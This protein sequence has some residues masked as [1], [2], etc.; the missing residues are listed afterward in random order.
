MN[1]VKHVLSSLLLWRLW[2]SIASAAPDSET[3]TSCAVAVVGGGWAGIY[4]AWRLVVDEKRFNGSEVCMFEAS[5]RIGGR[6]YTL[7]AHEA[8]QLEGL[9]IDIGAYRF[10]FEQHLPADL[11]RGPL[12]MSTGCYIPSCK[13]EPLDDDLVLHRLVDS[14]SGVSIGYGSALVL[15]MKQLSAMG[16]RTA[17]WHR[18]EAI[19]PSGPHD[20]QLVWKE[21]NATSKHVT[22]ASSVFLNFPRHAVNSLQPGSVL[23]TEAPAPTQQLFSC[24]PENYGH[25]ETEASVKVYMVYEEA[26]WIS[27]LGLKEGEVKSL[28]TDPPLYIRYHDGPTHCRGDTCRGALLVQYSHTLEEGSG[29]YLQFQQN[30]S[31]PLGIFTNGSLLTQVHQKLMDMHNTSLRSQGIDPYRLPGPVAAVV[32]FWRH[33]KQVVLS[34]APDPLSFSTSSGVPPCLQGT[35][36]ATYWKLTRKPLARRSIFIANNDWWLEQS[37]V[38]L[39][40]PYWAEVSLRTAERV[41]HDNFGLSRPR[42]LNESYFN[43]SVLGRGLEDEEVIV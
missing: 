31:E 28:Q 12:N 15:M 2:H 14:E 20:V 22:K 24:S 5:G 19:Y 1:V 43:H 26:W 21:G 36:S 25:E 16:V 35:S 34:P 17:L 32:G 9:N 18:L 40:P 37:K 29:W 10:A 27:K 8:P 13:P 23:F 41:L 30:L 39:M 6:T 33:A 11:L 4:A 42:W 38:D 7:F 3:P